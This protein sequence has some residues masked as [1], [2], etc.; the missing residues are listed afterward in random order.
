MFKKPKSKKQYSARIERAGIAIVRVKK[1]E[2]KAT[3]VQLVYEFTSD[4]AGAIGGDA[5]AQQEML[6]Q[7][8]DLCMT[9]SVRLGIDDRD[10]QVI[11]RVGE[12]DLSI[13]QA[14]G[15]KATAK[16]PTAEGGGP[17]LLVTVGFR[18]DDDDGADLA[19]GFLHAHLG[20]TVM[21]EMIRQA[22]AQ[23]ELDLE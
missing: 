1:E 9:K 5:I 16:R 4:V 22:P 8:G 23:G 2:K 17:V 13:D 14:S 7:G 3:S 20:E 6:A 11:F 12:D 18:H 10:V 15:I 21:V 19:L